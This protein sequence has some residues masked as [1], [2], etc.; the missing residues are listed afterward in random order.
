[1]NEIQRTALSHTLES[2]ALP[3]AEEGQ[4]G[5]GGNTCQQNVNVVS[6]YCCVAWNGTW[7]KPS[8]CIV[9]A[10][11]LTRHVGGRGD[12][13]PTGCGV[14]LWVRS[15]RCHRCVLEGRVPL[16][17]ISASFIRAPRPAPH[18]CKAAFWW[19]GGGK[20]EKGSHVGRWVEDA[21]DKE[22]R[23]SSVCFA[24]R[25]DVFT[26][27]ILRKWHLC[28]FAGDSYY[29]FIYLFCTFCC[30]FLRQQNAWVNECDIVCFRTQ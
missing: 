11:Q 25:W 30:R 26:S 13:L 16:P 14:E 8:P 23:L 21:G 29:L 9:H 2:N 18:T 17:Y 7:N 4:G 12:K 5:C 6:H 28:P 24:G 10:S 1:M 3:E 27:H 15:Q 22:R 19:R 20:G